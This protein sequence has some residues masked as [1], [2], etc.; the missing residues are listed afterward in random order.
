MIADLP[1]VH[2]R[3]QERRAAEI[4]GAHR[5]PIHDTHFAAARARECGE[6]A[7]A[8]PSRPEMVRANFGSRLERVDLEPAA[9]VALREHLAAVARRQVALV[10][11]PL[12]VSQAAK[13]HLHAE[14]SSVNKQHLIT[15]FVDDVRDMYMYMYSTYINAVPVMSRLSGAGERA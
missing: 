6:A 13:Q 14:K 12:F 10:K 2:E 8:T 7:F 4:A 11:I 3:A 15:H 1:Q 9:A 5:R